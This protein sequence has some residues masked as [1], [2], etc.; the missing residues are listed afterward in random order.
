MEL[1]V[2]KN[3]ILCAVPYAGNF[4]IQIGYIFIYSAILQICDEE[5]KY[6]GISGFWVAL[7]EGEQ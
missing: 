2:W 7:K 5:E 3:R 4:R 1:E 6:S